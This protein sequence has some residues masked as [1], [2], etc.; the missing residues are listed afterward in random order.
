MTAHS[1]L[2]KLSKE[3]FEEIMEN[4]SVQRTI[5]KSVI[6]YGDDQEKTMFTSI[7][8]GDVRGAVGGLADK[9]QE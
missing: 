7:I 3:K 6:D 9:V 5:K 4:R 8:H 2:L 1:R